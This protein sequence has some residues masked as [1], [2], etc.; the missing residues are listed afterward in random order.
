MKNIVLGVTGSIAAYKA[1]DL[2]RLLVKADFKVKVVMTRHA[3]EFVHPNTF[4]ALSGHRVYDD[5]FDPEVNSMMHIELAKWAD[6]VLIA[7]ASASIIGKLASGIADDLLTTVCLATSKRIIL[8][9]SMNKEMWANPIVVDNVKKLQEKYSYGLLAPEVGEQACGDF[10]EGRL[11][12]PEKIVNFF[13]SNEKLKGRRVLITAGP[14]Q[15]AI[16]PVR[17]ISN[18]SSGKMGYALAKAARDLGAEVTLISGPCALEMP[19]VQKILRVTTADEMSQA[20][21]S[22]IKN[23]DVFISAAAVADYKPK[24]VSKNKIKKSDEEFNLSLEKTTDI[25]SALSHLTKKPFMVG[26]AAETDNVI[27]NAKS[28][29]NKKNLDLIIANKVTPNFPFNSDENEI[30]LITKNLEILNF[31]RAQKIN[32]AHKIMEKIHELI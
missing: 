29:L 13:L 23:C 19:N 30:T 26:F 28:K 6:V 20:V 18:H 17:Y 8:A 21:L 16:D 25:L 15:E 1:A 22:E 7:P 2:V 24:I 9:P 14:T 32:L 3:K 12:E 27:D 31:E 5:L 11:M 10:G 4:S